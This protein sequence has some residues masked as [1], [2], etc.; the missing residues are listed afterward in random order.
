MR[1]VE[2]VQTQCLGKDTLEIAKYMLVVMVRGILD[3][4]TLRARICK[5][6]PLSGKQ[7]DSIGLKVLF[8]GAGPNRKFFKLH[9]QPLSPMAEH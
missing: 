1:F 2:L 7:F 3:S 8:D 6:S 5:S 9:M 4:P